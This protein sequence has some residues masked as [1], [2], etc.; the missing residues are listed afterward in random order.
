MLY[1]IDV[2]DKFRM[3]GLC[4]QGRNGG[5]VRVLPFPLINYTL[6]DFIK[7]IKHKPLKQVAE[8]P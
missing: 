2:K 6:F 1:F 3:I 7:S 5:E 8:M 4:S